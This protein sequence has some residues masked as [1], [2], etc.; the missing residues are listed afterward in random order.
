MKSKFEKLEWPHSGALFNAGGIDL[1]WKP[2]PG[3]SYHVGRL[4]EGSP[5][6]AYFKQESRFAVMPAEI[7]TPSGVE[8][9][10]AEAEQR[11]ID[12]FETV[13]VPRIKL[14]VKTR[15]RDLCEGAVYGTLFGVFVT[16]VAVYFFS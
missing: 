9:S 6:G 15:V 12:H 7:L 13:I 5:I 2:A 3:V 11:C 16:L 14:H 8:D 1:I 10:Q 4:H